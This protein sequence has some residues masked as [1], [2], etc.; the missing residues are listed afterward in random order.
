MNSIIFKMKEDKKIPI[1]LW[2]TFW[3]IG[4][5]MINVLKRELTMW[6]Q[7]QIVKFNVF[8]VIKYLDDKIEHCYRIRISD[9]KLQRGFDA[10]VTKK[11]Y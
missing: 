8:I 10:Y 4:R 3:D 1:I 7:D 2:G 5:T 11:N 9:N 6:V